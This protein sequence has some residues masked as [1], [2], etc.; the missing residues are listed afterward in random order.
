M[1]FLAHSGTRRHPALLQVLAN[2][3]RAVLARFD[4]LATEH[5][6]RERDERAR[7]DLDRLGDFH[8]DDIGVVRSHRRTVWVDMPRG[9][10]MVLP[11][12][13]TYR[14][15]DAGPFPTRTRTLVS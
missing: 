5:C 3:S 4:R 2:L 12:E 7:R 6:R 8:L 9:M 15:K 13:F 11:E 10:P 1:S 14:C